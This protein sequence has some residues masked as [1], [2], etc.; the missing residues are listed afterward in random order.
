[1]LHSKDSSLDAVQNSANSLD[2]PDFT[3]IDL[4]PKTFTLGMPHMACDGVSRGWLLRQA[5]HAHWGAIASRLQARPTAFQDR[6]GAR[7]LPSVV[8]CT[9]SGDATKFREDDVCTKYLTEKPRPENGWRSQLELRSHRADAIRAEIVTSFARRAGGSNR[10]LEPANLGSVFQTTRNHPEMRRTSLIRRFGNSMRARANADSDP[11]HRIV[12]IDRH[13]H[14]NGVGLVY[15]AAIH[16]I[17]EAAEYNAL[18][19]PVQAWPMRERRVH[20]FA[21]LDVG[22]CLEVTSRASAQSLVPSASV[23]VQS[24]ARRG[25]DGKVVVVSESTYSP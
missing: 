17:L 6:D 5:C 2:E 18:P 4:S 8:A 7:V 21:N 13:Q 14:V 19:G 3:P 9:I 10:S 22:D 20:Y 24:H 1:M 23:V 15:F 16:D 25:S 12:Q 11:P